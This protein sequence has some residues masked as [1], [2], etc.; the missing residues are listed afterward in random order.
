MRRQDETGQGGFASPRTPT[1][2]KRPTETA[3]GAQ[4]GEQEKI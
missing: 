3:G 2:P 4:G 1:D